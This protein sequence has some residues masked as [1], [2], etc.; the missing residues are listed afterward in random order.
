M[1]QKCAEIVPSGVCSL[2]GCEHRGVARLRLVAVAIVPVAQNRRVAG[3]AWPAPLRPLQAGAIPMSALRRG[4]DRARCA[5][6]LR[7]WPAL[8]SIE[9]SIMTQPWNAR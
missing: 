3:R 2:L 8:T 1:E 9:A 4:V 5:A 7:R 6:T